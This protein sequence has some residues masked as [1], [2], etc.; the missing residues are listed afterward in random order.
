MKS[1]LIRRVLSLPNAT[2]E[3]EKIKKITPISNMET[4]NHNSDIIFD[5]IPYTIEWGDIE[6]AE[7]DYE[8]YLDDIEHFFRED[9]ENDILE[10][11]TL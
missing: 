2:F 3:I 10:E 9:F 5:E 1:I 4:T 6:N 8:N 11:D 7:M